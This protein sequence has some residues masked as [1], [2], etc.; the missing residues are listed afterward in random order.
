MSTMSVDTL[1]SAL[2]EQFGGQLISRGDPGYDEARAVYN[3]MIDRRPALL[4]RCCDV[5]DVIAGVR[6]A[7]AFGGPL[8][9]RGGG[10]NGAGLGTTE[11]GLVLDLSPMQGIRVD[12]EKGTIRVDGGCTWG[13]VDHA[14]HAFDSAVPCGI[15]STTGVGGLALGGGTGYLT[16][17]HGLTIDNLVSADVVLADGS[18]VAADER[19][20]PD[21]FWALRGGGG[22][23]G[24]VTS[25][26]FKLCP[27]S[28]VVA[29]PTF[30]PLEQTELVLR[31]YRDFILE[32]PEDLYGFFA[33]LTVPPVP[34]FPP[35]LH[36]QK[37]CGVVWCYL[38]DPETAEEA[39]APVREVGSPALHAV[40]PMPFPTLNSTFDDLYPKGL[41]WYWRADFATEVSDEAVSRHVEF[42]EVPTMHM[43]PV[44]GAA[45]RVPPDGTAFSYRDANW[46]VVYAGVDP[47]PANAQIIRDWAV[48]YQ[49]AL[50]PYSTGGAYVNFLGADEGRERVRASYRGNYERLARVKAEYDPDNLFRVNQN[51]E[52]AM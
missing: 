1:S 8:A 17:K 50:H 11:G 32:A 36:L 20:H 44:D 16:R 5:A 9:V 38:G 23:F 40:Q 3:A 43:Y 18:L 46:N 19:S 29:G 15:I 7:A 34:P 13:Q 22:N 45:H 52:P 12:P 6:A 31:W 37:V 26:E 49:S 10:H 42:A 14:A 48:A 2:S 33:T 30:W 47:D 27:V 24:V 51:I 25:F 39:F 28:T 4:A 21:L 35:G 41:Q